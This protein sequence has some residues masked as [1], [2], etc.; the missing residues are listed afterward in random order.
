MCVCVGRQTA[1]SRVLSATFPALQVH[2]NVTDLV[3][4]QS[5]LEKTCTL[6]AFAQL[7]VRIQS[8]SETRARAPETSGGRYSLEQILG[9]DERNVP[10]VLALFD[11]ALAKI[12]ANDK[13]HVAFCVSGI[14]ACLVC[15]GVLQVRAKD[16]RSDPCCC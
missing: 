15:Y 10:M 16:P 13:A 6:R 4:L 1:A 7:L 14:I 2:E 3:G 9:K 8:P 5:S 11:A 12:K